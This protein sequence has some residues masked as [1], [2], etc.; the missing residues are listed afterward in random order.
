M[1]CRVPEHKKAVMHLTEKLC[2]LDQLPS[3]MSDSVV[4]PKFN[5]K[6]QQNVLNTMSL[7]RKHR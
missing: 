3:D 1:L 2:A 5:D 4:G 7:N 6:N